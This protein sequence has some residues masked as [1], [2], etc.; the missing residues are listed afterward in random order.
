MWQSIIIYIVLATSF[1]ISVYNVI[2]RFR[3]PFSE[4][5]GCGLSCGS[6]AIDDLKQKQLKQKETY[7]KLNSK[8]KKDL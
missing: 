2:K 3:K 5:D 7:E 8:G 4:C 1:I 6:C